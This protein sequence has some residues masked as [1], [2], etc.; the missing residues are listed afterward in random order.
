MKRIVVVPPATRRVVDI[1]RDIPRV[2][3]EEFAK[4]IGA[5][6]VA[7]DKL[8]PRW[9]AIVGTNMRRGR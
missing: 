7:F 1:P 6:P 9:Q 8:P 3:G 5:E 2:S 4:A